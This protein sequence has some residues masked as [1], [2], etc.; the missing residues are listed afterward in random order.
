MPDH[1]PTHVL[2]PSDGETSTATW[3]MH[4]VG[5]PSIGH[6]PNLPPRRQKVVGQNHH[7]F[8]QHAIDP[9]HASNHLTEAIYVIRQGGGSIQSISSWML[10]S[11]GCNAGRFPT[12]PASA[13]SL[14][15][16]GIA[17]ATPFRSACC[18]S[19]SSAARQWSQKARVSCG[20]DH[21]HSPN[22]HAEGRSPRTVSG[23]A[24]GAART[25]TITHRSPAAP[26]KFLTGHESTGDHGC[27]GVRARSHDQ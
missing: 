2:N 6:L 25:R 16:P 1:G 23:R 19:R 20:A 14:R 13:N 3:V 11:G 17:S 8:P 4:W 9:F 10:D 22:R 21:R 5:L 18:S 24:D 15:S 27:G 12:T 26:A 7:P